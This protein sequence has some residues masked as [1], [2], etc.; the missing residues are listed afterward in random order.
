MQTCK[1]SDCEGEERFSAQAISSSPKIF[2]QTK[3]EEILN[4]QTGCLSSWPVW[5]PVSPGRASATCCW[6]W[7]TSTTRRSSTETSNQA[8]YS[9]SPYPS[10]NCK[11]KNPLWIWFKCAGPTLGRWRLPTWVWATSLT[12]R[13]P[14]SPPLQV[15][16]LSSNLQLILETPDHQM[17]L[18]SF[19]FGCF[20]D[21][22]FRNFRFLELNQ[23]FVSESLRIICAGTPAFTAPE[24]LVSS[25]IG[26]QF[27]T[28]FY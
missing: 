3:L 18:W 20:W 12:G 7:S 2:F 27:F 14:S 21:T 24:S 8:T 25:E 9:G 23:S 15:P 16:F 28:S 1:S 5:W 10:V 13:T 19:C 11:K 17:V 6:A 4:T 26:F 22:I